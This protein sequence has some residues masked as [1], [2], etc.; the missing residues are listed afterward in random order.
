MIRRPPRSTL[1]PY[2]TLFRSALAS[3]GRGRR[4]NRSRGPPL[5]A[6]SPTPER[7][8]AG[9]P[10]TGRRRTKLHRPRRPRSTAVLVLSLLR[11]VLRGVDD[12]DRHAR[13]AVRPA[14]RDHV[15]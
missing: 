2:T 1:F 6:A 9:H 7:R 3:G 13:A 14:R 12:R 5:A 15:V 10:A 4:D 8:L 11:F